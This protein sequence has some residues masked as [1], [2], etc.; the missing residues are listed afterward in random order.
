MVDVDT[1]VSKSIY[2]G[3]GRT[4]VCKCGHRWEDHFLE[5]T[6]NEDYY[7]ETSEMYIPLQCQFYEPDGMR[8]N[9]KPDVYGNDAWIMHCNCYIDSSEE[10][11]P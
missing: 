8:H 4:G 2:S 9:E 5:V 10:Q 7:Q 6:Q 3:P 11:I 1:A